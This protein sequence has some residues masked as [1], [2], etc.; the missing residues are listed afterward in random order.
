MVI[1]GLENRSS[2]T[3]YISHSSGI[4][5]NPC[6]SLICIQSIFP[7]YIYI[8]PLVLFIS[9]Y[10][11]SGKF[12]QFKRNIPYS[13]FIQAFRSLILVILT[14]EV[15]RV[16][17]WKGK[18]LEA[19]GATGQVIIDVIP[20]VELIVGPQPNVA[21]LPPAE[22]QNRFNQIF[23]DFI[24][25]FAQASHPLVIFLDDLQWADLSTLSLLRLVLMES[26]RKYLFIIG[27]YR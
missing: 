19:L 13:G 12:D 14:E 2:F 10:F 6:P 21:P 26:D 8:S 23:Q 7:A 24:G 20:E 9:R 27:A 16:Q 18:L 17:Y 4:K 22:N 1:L 15:A 11:I 25:V 3:K 5:G